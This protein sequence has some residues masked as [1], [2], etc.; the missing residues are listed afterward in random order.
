MGSLVLQ[1]AHGG[2]ELNWHSINW[3][4]CYRAVK[5]LQKRIVKALQEGNW[6][7]VKRLSYLLVRSLAG[8][9]MAVKRVTENS[10]KKTAGIDGK[11]WKT[12][13]Q[14]AKAVEKIGQWKNY[15]PYPLK[16]LYI[17][18]PNNPTK[19]RPLSIPTMEERGRQALY[20]QALQA[21]AETQADPNSYGFR[22]KRQGADAIDQCFK[23]LRQ[24]GSAVW[25]LE[26]DIKGFFN[27]I[28]FQWI[29]ENIPMNKKV[30]NQWLQCGF[31]DN[32]TFHPTEK[33]VPQGGI[34]SPIIGNMVLDGLEKLVKG[35][36]H[37]QRTNHIHFVRYA[38][39]FI[40]MTSSKEVLEETIIPKIKAFLEPRGVGLSEEK[41]FITHISEG[42]D[43]LG[44]T[45]RKFPR[46][47]GKS[48]KLQI[49]PSKRSVQKIKA[50][51]KDICKSSKGLSQSQLI[52]RL[53]PVIRGWANYHRHSQCAETFA[54]IDSYAW[55]R[56][57]RWAKRRHPN[58]TGKWIASRYFSAKNGY[59]WTFRDRL[60]DKDLIHSLPAVPYQRHIKVKAN[61]N[62]F[63]EK[64]D[65]YFQ[66]RAFK[67]KIRSVST[68]K[69]RIVKRQKGI[70]PVCQQLIQVDEEVDLHH[71][72]ENHDN[73]HIGNLVFLHPNCHRQIHHAK[74][75]NNIVKS[76]VLHGAFCNA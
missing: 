67:L 13:Q 66:K 40:V 7:K 60:L 63:C 35:T 37:F 46:E 9:T 50:K 75:T 23:A 44:Q 55:E 76:R 72:D 30:L 62:P 15:R 6:R 26:A 16:R 1:A 38:D 25:V 70:C 61:A 41:T 17:P 71:K 32:N 14:K 64:W 49:T 73:D 3:S 45:I 34:I 48:S 12:P 65:E 24:K 51:I 27:N 56:V 4:G 8:R 39:D 28:C 53:N 11:L 59:K 29:V 18:K 58:K 54:K 69:G 20:M 47:K 42:F 57:Y 22:A 43:F 36:T 10:G 52:D 74:I 2:T 19:K 21:I 5:S 68:F 33:G 31:I